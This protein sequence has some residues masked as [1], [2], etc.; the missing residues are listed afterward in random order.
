MFDPDL[1]RVRTSGHLKSPASQLRHLR[2]RC[3][4]DFLHDIAAAMRISA[5]SRLKDEEHQAAPGFQDILDWHSVVGL[6]KALLM[7]SEVTI[8]GFPAVSK[9]R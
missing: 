2:A 4:C 7:F 8:A 6:R 3:H 5:D 1:V 9:A